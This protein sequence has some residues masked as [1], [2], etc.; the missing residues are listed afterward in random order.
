M[1]QP[2]L[3]RQLRKLEH[4]LCAELFER[5]SSGVRLTVFGE[6]LVSHAQIIT[7]AQHAARQDVD[8]LRQNLQ[9]HVTFGVSVTIT[10]D[11]FGQGRHCRCLSRPASLEWRRAPAARWHCGGRERLERHS[12][13]ESAEVLGRSA[14]ARWPYLFQPHVPAEAGTQSLPNNQN[15]LCGSWIPAVADVIQITDVEPGNEVP[16]SHSTIFAFTRGRIMNIATRTVT[17]MTGHTEPTNFLHHDIAASHGT[18]PFDT[19]ARMPELKD[20]IVQPWHHSPGGT[21]QLPG[22]H[23]SANVR[24][25]SSVEGHGGGQAPMFNLWI[26]HPGDQFHHNWIFGS[27]L[28]DVC[29]GGNFGNDFTGRGDGDRFYGGTG[30]DIYHYLAWWDST[31]QDPDKIYG[32]DPMNDKMDVR[33]LVSA[34]GNLV[35]ANL[36]AA[37]DSNGEH[38]ERLILTDNSKDQF[39]PNH[40]LEIDLYIAHTPMLQS[41]T[42]DTSNDF[43]MHSHTDWLVS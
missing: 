5:T 4:E 7:Q 25:V 12:V 28:R 23:D 14:E 11:L 27:E 32:F 37:T 22:V 18:S 43:Y 38:Y 15:Y 34:H 10:R 21:T 19:V 2:A 42:A 41:Q 26:E 13:D 24:D 35:V 6:S 33:S 3:S 39:A 16:R 8:R 9:G 29:F 31:Q 36:D 1:T 20:L 40:T 30:Q 17:R